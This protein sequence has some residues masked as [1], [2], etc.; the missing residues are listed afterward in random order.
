MR[1]IEASLAAGLLLLLCP[2]VWRVLLHKAPFHSTCEQRN[3]TVSFC[4]GGSYAASFTHS[5]WQLDNKD[6]LPCSSVL[7]VHSVIP[8]NNGLELSMFHVNSSGDSVRVLHSVNQQAT[9]YGLQIQDQID[10]YAPV[11]EWLI[12]AND[13]VPFVTDGTCETRSNGHYL[14]WTYSGPLLA[15]HSVGIWDTWQSAPRQNATNYIM[16]QLD[17]RPI[18]AK[19]SDGN[20]RS[21]I[22]TA[23]APAQPLLWLRRAICDE[24]TPALGPSQGPQS[25]TEQKPLTP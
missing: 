25:S 10:V 24:S 7:R 8:L 5:S 14:H 11:A 23:L 16:L 17:N 3:F 15:K 2:W 6:P 18:L 13:G 21:F 20:L 12:Q 1:A 22:C 19:E 9:I 4:V